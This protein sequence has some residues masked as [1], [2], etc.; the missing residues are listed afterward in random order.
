MEIEMLVGKSAVG[1]HP[2]FHR[3]VD[4]QKKIDTQLDRI[5]FDSRDSRP[6]TLG[7]PEREEL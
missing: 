5:R 1:P 7:P 6:E 4:S 3:F 2:K